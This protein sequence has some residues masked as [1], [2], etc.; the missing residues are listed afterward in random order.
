MLLGEKKEAEE[1]EI[2]PGYQYDISCSTTDVCPQW[3]FHWQNSSPLKLGDDEAASCSILLPSLHSRVR[4]VCLS[5]TVCFYPA[6][7]STTNPLPLDHIYMEAVPLCTSLPVNRRDGCCCFCCC[8]CSLS[9]TWLLLMNCGRL[10]GEPP[11]LILLCNSS[12]R[13]R[14]TPC[15][16]LFTLQSPQTASSLSGK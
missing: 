13:G 15:T 7:S 2:R 16:I 1:R 5:V 11:L 6:S 4:P 9:F 12:I 8:C 10:I 14:N 3:Q